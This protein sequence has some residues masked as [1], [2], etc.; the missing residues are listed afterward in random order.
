MKR[1]IS[2][3]ISLLICAVAQAQ[4]PH[5]F[6]SEQIAL[7]P[8][9]VSCQPGDTVTV[10][11]QVT[12]LAAN[13]IEP[14]SNYLYIELINPNDSIVV[15]QK[16]SCKNKGSFAA[17]LPIDQ[18]GAYGVYY[19][20]AYTQLM[21]NFSHESFALQP[22]LVGQ[23]FP[24]FDP[25]TTDGVKCT[26]VPHGG[27][28]CS[29]APQNIT[30]RVA[31]YLNDPLSNIPLALT[32]ENGDTIATQCTSASGLAV[33]SF[34]PQPNVKYTM[35]LVYERVKKVFPM[36]G[37]NDAQ[38]I[39]KA[40]LKGSQVAFSILGGTTDVQQLQLYTYDRLNGI[41][42]IAI[43]R[44]AGSFKLANAPQMI[45][46]FLTDAKTNLLAQCTVMAR[47]E[48][49]PQPA[50][51]QTAAIGEPL[52]LPNLGD[53]A[54]VMARLVPMNARWVEHAES[55]LLYLSDLQSPLPFP[56]NCYTLPEHQRDAEL[57]A[58]MGTAS[59]KRFNI[60]DAV[61]QDTAIY[62]FLPE[63]VMYFQ[64]KIESHSKKPFNNGSL[65]AFN[66]ENN[67]VYNAE[68]NKNGE[69]TIAVDDFDDGTCFFLQAVNKKNKPEAMYVRINDDTYPAFQLA[70]RKILEKNLYVKTEVTYAGGNWDKQ[71]LPEITVKAHTKYDNLHST[72]RFYGHAYK[73]RK[74]IEERGFLTLYDILK[75]I[76][77]IS[78]RR[79]AKTEDEN[80]GFDD[81]IS[82][83][84][85]QETG[86]N[87]SD[88][89]DSRVEID[90]AIFSSR[91]PSSLGKKANQVVM[92]INGQRT[93]EPLSSLLQMSSFE[94]ES[95]EYLRP[96]QALSYTF[97]ALTGAI[98]VVTRN[99]EKPRD[100][101]SKGTLYTPIGLSH[102]ATDTLPVADKPGKY[103][104]IVDVVSPSGIHSYESIV[105]ALAK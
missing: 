63:D 67:A 37:C 52:T 43:N 40:S 84:K 72:T 11:G 82:G 64:G 39:V 1:F 70:E 20:R 42:H 22:L 9:Q 58:W 74:T 53:N 66:T 100:V 15:R 99:Y 34:I 83:N 81:P 57:M 50:L 56:E 17:A 23:S 46:L 60:A 35:N 47:G 85:R 48:E 105:T 75:D 6:R 76:H 41:S 2:Y 73:D 101:K 94:I 95:V 86:G 19:I 30:I 90:Y 10:L 88:P 96:W 77:G 7:C 54:N 32:T 24:D 104:L 8:Q 21:R 103:R 31:N 102:Q 13:R 55:Q 93:P 98:N 92:L 25:I 28:L 87:S 26:V 80:G 68:L 14:Y 18:L 69:F 51:P 89:K 4:L 79:V 45:T 65:V 78:I 97:G 38:P 91:G 16:V 5:D 27:H 3:I 12:C 29:G 36:Q 61:K 59:F 71:Q 33:M 44:L 62:T 49:T